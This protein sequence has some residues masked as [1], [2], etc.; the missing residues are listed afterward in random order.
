MAMVAA[1]Q[2]AAG[3]ERSAMNATML[4]MGTFRVGEG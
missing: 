3:R 4:I 2:V 1:D